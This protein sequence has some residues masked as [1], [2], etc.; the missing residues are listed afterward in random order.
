MLA[1]LQQRILFGFVVAICAWGL[2]WWRWS[3]ALAVAGMVL[4]LLGHTLVLGLECVAVGVANRRDPAPAPQALQLLRAWGQETLMALRVFCWRQPFRPDAVPDYLPTNG[5]A[6][7]RQGVVLLHGLVCNRGFWAP[8]M[9]ELR[10][11]GVPCVAVNLEPVFAASID[12]YV[13]QVEAAVAQVAAATGRP[14]LLLCHSMGGLAAR[15]WLRW[16]GDARRVRRI[17][18]IGSPHHGTAL[19]AFSHTG[20][21]LQMRLDSAWLQALAQTESTER[22][23]LFSCWYSNCD[24]IVFPASTATLAGADSYFVPGLPHVALA[25]HPPLMAAVLDEIAPRR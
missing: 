4:L 11:R 21:G 5:S 12:D 23:A 13:P 14:P 20:N 25:F 2:L 6:Q 16:A 22:R 10:R 8:W 19:A 15:A 7:G 17:V 9:T 1:R 18:T 24:Q 3:P